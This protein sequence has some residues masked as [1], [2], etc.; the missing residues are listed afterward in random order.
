MEQCN[1]ERKVRIGYEYD[2]STTCPAVQFKLLLLSLQLTTSK[3]QCELDLEW[4][5][6]P[7]FRDPCNEHPLG[8]FEQNCIPLAAAAA[9]L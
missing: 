1:D 9:A 7:S 4:N 2:C 6:Y 8:P 5:I 3:W